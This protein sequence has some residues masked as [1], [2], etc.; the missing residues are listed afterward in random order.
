MKA[1]AAPFLRDIWYA[2]L[3]SKELKAGRLAHRT[4]LGEPFVFARQPDGEVFALRDLCPHRGV[5]LS[6][7]QLKPGATGNEIE[8]PYH[9]WRFGASGACTA[10][11]SLVQGQDMAIDRISVRR[12]ETREKQ[13]NI[14]VFIP[15][16]GGP[17]PDAPAEPPDVPLM[18]SDAVPRLIEAMTFHCHVDHAVIGLMDPAHGPYV[19][20]AWWWRTESSMHE[21]QKSFHP[22]P[23]GFAMTAHKPSSN[24]FLYRLLGG[25]VKTE[26]T[27]RLPGIRIEAI[28]AGK[29]C[30]V[31]LTTVTPVTETETEVRQAF[32]WNAAWVGLLKPILRP[33]SVTFLHQDRSMVDLQAEGLKHDPN[34]MLIDDADRQAKWYFQLKREWLAAREENRAFEHPIKEATVLRWRS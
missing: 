21:K 7:G 30:V 1:D 4:L 3:P 25:E 17:G 11:P 16:D 8:C 28:T 9:G 26:I 12:Y 34:L 23:Y 14:W 24:S 31:G 5:Y 32:Y 13:G 19:H 22:T 6:G 2:A 27:F 10:I 33:F 29:N 20:R 15:S 18:G